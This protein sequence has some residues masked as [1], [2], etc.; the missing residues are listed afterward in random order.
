ME[1]DDSPDYN[2]YMCNEIKLNHIRT[3]I[4]KS[5]EIWYIVFD[6]KLIER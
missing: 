1:G 6:N 4:V 5:P 3:F 2:Q